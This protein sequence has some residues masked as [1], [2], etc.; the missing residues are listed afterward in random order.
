[1]SPSGPPYDTSTQCRVISYAA[2]ALSCWRSSASPVEQVVD[3]GGGTGFCTQGVVK[4]VPPTNV[5]LLDQSPHQLE[6][7]RKKADLQGIS[8]VE[9]HYNPNRVVAHMR[10]MSVYCRLSVLRRRLETSGQEDGIATCTLCSLIRSSRALT[11]GL[12][13]LMKDLACVSGRCRGLT[14]GPAELTKC[15]ACVSG[16]CRGSALC[17]RLLRPI[18]FSWQHRV[19]ARATEGHKRSLQVRPCPNTTNVVRGVAGSPSIESALH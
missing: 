8:I 18:C 6:K 15:L 12:A 9:V 7:A 2:A 16:R 1:M 10:Q 3:V 19:L 5:T 11:G 4:T 13:E 17:H 14:G